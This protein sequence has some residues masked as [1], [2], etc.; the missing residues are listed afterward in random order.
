[1]YLDIINFLAAITAI[2]SGYRICKARVRNEQ[3]SEVRRSVIL[4]VIC[5]IILWFVNIYI[6]FIK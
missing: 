5:L 1:M 6:G 4:F 2:Y 3:L